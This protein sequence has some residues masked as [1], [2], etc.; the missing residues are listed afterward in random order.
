MGFCYSIDV[1]TTDALVIQAGKV[2]A[3]D[4]RSLQVVDTVPGAVPSRATLEYIAN[5]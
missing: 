3:A 1:A 5:G 2:M 4:M